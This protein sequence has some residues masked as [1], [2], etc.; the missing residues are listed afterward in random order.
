[1]AVELEVK[2][3][4]GQLLEQKRLLPDNLAPA[5]TAC[6]CRTMRRSGAGPS[7]SRLP[8]VAAS[9]GLFWWR[10]FCRSG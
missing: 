1:M 5:T 4:D 7:T 8:P 2:Q 3:P 6:V 9:S 10:S